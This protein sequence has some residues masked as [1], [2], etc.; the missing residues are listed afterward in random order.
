MTSSSSWSCR[1]SADSTESHV[2]IGEREDGSRGGGDGGD[3]NVAMGGVMI[4]DGNGTIWWRV[5]VVLIWP[6]TALARRNN[7]TARKNMNRK[8]DP[9]TGISIGRGWTELYKTDG[10]A[11]FIMVVS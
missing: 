1:G 11:D 2:D 9:P 5:S 3:G 4:V 7:Y 10:L 8:G 6:C